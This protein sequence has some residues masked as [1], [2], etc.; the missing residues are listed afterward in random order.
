MITTLFFGFRWSFFAPDRLLISATAEAVTLARIDQEIRD[1]LS[2][3]VNLHL[4]RG[5]FRCRISTRKL[6]DLAREC[7]VVRGKME[8]HRF[9]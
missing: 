3:P 5:R 1:F 6:K 4:L 9:R 7:G 2:D 8:E